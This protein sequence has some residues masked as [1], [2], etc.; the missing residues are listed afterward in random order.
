LDCLLENGNANLDICRLI[1]N[2]TC[3]LK[4]TNYRNIIF[5]FGGVIINIDPQLTV[6][7]F[8]ELC[9]DLSKNEANR[10]IKDPLFRQF[11]KGMISESQLRS[12]IYKILNIESLQF[13]DEEF[14]RAWNAMILD[15]PKSRLDLLL[16]LSAEHRIFLL[17]NTNSIH[18]RKVSEVVQDTIQKDSINH[19]FE[20]TYYSYLIGMQ[21]PDREIFDFVLKENNLHPDETIFLDDFPENFS[22]A[23]EAGIDT[24]EVDRDIIDIFV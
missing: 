9:N 23:K 1:H 6:K 2:N 13:T 11:E 22:G 4:L 15:L 18:M 12:G 5:D 24:L 21:K 7:A 3:I 16:T 19:Y 14:D 10:V 20:N 17:S 8:M